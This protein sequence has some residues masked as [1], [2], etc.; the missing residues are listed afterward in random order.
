M[1]HLIVIL[2]FWH[3][4]NNISAFVTLNNENST[5]ESIELNFT[6]QS[7]TPYDNAE[8][9]IIIPTTTNDTTKD[10]LIGKMDVRQE[11]H[12]DERIN[13][14]SCNM[15]QLPVECRIWKGNETNE[16][17]IP[18]KV[19]FPFPFIFLS[20]NF[21]YNTSEY[22]LFTSKTIGNLAFCQYYDE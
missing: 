10:V 22:T 1:Q 20:L 11:M 21:R 9:T 14:L 6:N 16:M 13:S 5:S 2:F 4:V 15:P 12:I 19:H 18:K 8:T 3:Y 7:S 17:L